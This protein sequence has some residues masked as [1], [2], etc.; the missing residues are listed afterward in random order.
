MPGLVRKVMIL[1][2]V[3]GLLLLPIGPRS[4]TAGQTKITYKSATINSSPENDTAVSQ[5]VDSGNSFEAMGIAGMY[6]FL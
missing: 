4:R 6:L 2:A 5:A 1:A 3:D